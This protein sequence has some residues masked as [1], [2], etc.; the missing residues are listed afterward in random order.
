MPVYFAKNIDSNGQGGSTPYNLQFDGPQ[1]AIHLGDFTPLQ[2]YRV[3]CAITPTVYRFTV[4]VDTGVHTYEYPRA[5]GR[6]AKAI[7]F[8]DCAWSTAYYDD[9]TYTP[10]VVPVNLTVVSPYGTP[11]P[12]VGVHA[13]AAGT[14]VTC[15]AEAVASGSSRQAPV[16]W[17]LQGSTITTGSGASATFALNETS[18]LTWIWEQQYQLT[19]QTVGSGTITPA[20]G[21][22]A[23]GSTQPVQAQPSG[24]WLLMGWSG[25]AQAGHQTNPVS[26]VF[27]APKALTATFSQDADGDGLDNAAEAALG[28]DPR[29]KDSDDDGFDDQFEVQNGLVPTVSNAAIVNYIR[30]KPI[31]FD[32]Y[33]LDSL[34]DIDGSQMLIEVVNGEARLSLQMLQSTD[35]NQWTAAG[36]PQQW[37]FLLD[38]GKRFFRLRVAK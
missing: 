16:G 19:T 33:S 1:S 12:A 22:F 24:G 37:I 9:F 23:A 15:T 8:R 20:T 7:G 13:Y 5:A 35:L 29:D 34:I 28:T 36:A 14:Q 25:A 38:S 10:P 18:T 31:E 11:V 32:L 4:A 17:S 30:A 27:D 2:W 6:V 3:E 21:W 26:L